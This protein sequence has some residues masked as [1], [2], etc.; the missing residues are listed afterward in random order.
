MEE[1][2]LRKFRT[3][4]IGLTTT[5]SMRT[6]TTKHCRSCG[7]TVLHMCTA[8]SPTTIT[9]KKIQFEASIVKGEGVGGLLQEQFLN[10]DSDKITRDH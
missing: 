3:K 10:S 2:R 4:Y 8:V 6:I 7:G 1:Y 9:G 5:R